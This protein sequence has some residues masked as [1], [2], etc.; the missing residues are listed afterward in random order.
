MSW[1][2]FRER[3]DRS[4]GIDILFPIRSSPKSLQNFRTLGN[5]RRTSSV[6]SRHRPLPRARDISPS[7]P[8]LNRR[9]TTQYGTSYV[10]SRFSP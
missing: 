1:N 10:S 4:T 5:N 3:G 8:L 7:R 2:P 6:L 9:P